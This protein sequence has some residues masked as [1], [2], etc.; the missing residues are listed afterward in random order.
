MGRI[1]GLHGWLVE[2]RLAR[3]RQPKRCSSN[4][5]QYEEEKQEYDEKMATR[6]QR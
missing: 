4:E 1:R 2:E 6:A 3:L 5:Q